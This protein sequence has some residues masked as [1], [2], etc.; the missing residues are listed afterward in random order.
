MALDSH[1]KIQSLKYV[2]DGKMHGQTKLKLDY[3]VQSV[4]DTQQRHVIMTAVGKNFM[5]YKIKEANTYAST[6]DTDLA[7][8]WLEE[9]IISNKSNIWISNEVHENYLLHGGKGCR[10][11]VFAKLSRSILIT[12]WLFSLLQDSPIFWCFKIQFQVCSNLL[13]TMMTME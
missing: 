1:S 10:K 4:I 6:S 9:D 7:F 13:M 11:T 2:V 8:D 12:N 5:H 3:K